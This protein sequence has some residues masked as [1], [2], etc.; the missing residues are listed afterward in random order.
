[1]TAQQQPAK[2]KR[3]RL[4][5][6]R[7]MGLTLLCLALGTV[8]DLATERGLSVNLLTLMG[9]VISIYVTGNV[10]NKKVAPKGAESADQQQ[11]VINAVVALQ[12][13]MNQAEQHASGLDTKIDETSEAVSKQMS[14]ANKRL[15]A[16]LGAK[17][18]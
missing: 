6:G 15:T 14:A 16:I 2:P 1:M 13:R 7:K 4:H 12:E 11:Q 18:G 5:L 17:N 3:A 8:I 10:L 9:I